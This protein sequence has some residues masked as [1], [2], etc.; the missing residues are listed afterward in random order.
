M[1][2]IFVTLDCEMNNLSDWS[3]FG[4]WIGKQVRPDWDLSWGPMPLICGMPEYLSFAAKKALT[5]AAANYGCPMSVSYTHLR[6]HET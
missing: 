4:D 5:A 2:N 6:A 3:I 1:P